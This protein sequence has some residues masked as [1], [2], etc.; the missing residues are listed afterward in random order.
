MLISFTVLKCIMFNSI[1]LNELD[2]TVQSESSSDS[3]YI[4]TSLG[5][6]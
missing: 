3:E 5:K 1:E 6:E 2:N 4:F